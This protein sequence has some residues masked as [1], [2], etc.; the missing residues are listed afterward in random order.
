MNHYRISNPTLS[1]GATSTKGMY[2][3]VDIFAAGT[4]G[5]RE[6]VS[7]EQR[8]DV[9]GTYAVGHCDNDCGGHVVARVH[10]IGGDVL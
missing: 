8:L 4:Q 2:L 5:C 3:A 6:G 10:H 7:P 9:F 1:V